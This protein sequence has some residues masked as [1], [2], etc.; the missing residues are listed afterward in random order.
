MTSLAAPPGQAEHAFHPRPNLTRRSIS[1]QK[2]RARAPAVLHHFR[3]YATSFEAVQAAAIHWT[4]RAALGV[5]D[6]VVADT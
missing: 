5:V 6:T 4:H 2:D 1:H 3:A